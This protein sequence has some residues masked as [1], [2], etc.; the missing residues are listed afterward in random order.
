MAE[1][2]KIHSIKSNFILNILRTAVSFLTPL[3]VFPY[4]SRV[5]G[6]ENIGKVDFANSIISYFVLFTALGIPTYGVREV[7]RTRDDIIS[8]SK[9]VWELTIILCI[10]VPLGYVCYFFI[11]RII[12][13]FSKELLLFFTVAPSLFFSNFSYEWFYFGIEDQTYITVRHIFVKLLQI[14]GVYLFIREKEDYLLYALIIVGIGGISSIFNI[15]HLQTFVQR[16]PLKDLNIKH[17]IKPVLIIFTSIIATS[18]Y[19]QLDVTMVGFFSGDKAV[20]LY[21][22]ANRFVRTMIMLVTSLSSVIIP[23][24]ENCLKNNDE[25]ACKRYLDLSLHYI[26]MFSL[27]MMFGIIALGDD[28]IYILAGKQY[29]ESV[30]T[31]QLLSP[32]IVIVGLAYFVGLQILY[33]YRQ[34][35]KYTLAVSIAAFVNA[36]VNFLLIPHLAQNGAVIGTLVAELL[37]LLLQIIFASKHIKKTD[38]IS[39]NTLKYI[40]AA[41][42]MFVT[43]IF[44]P[45][46]ENVI[47]HFIISVFI[48]FII[49]GG[50]LLVLREKLIKEVWRKIFR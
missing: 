38:L 50:T 26:L 33:P 22:T 8:R 46:F 43:L 21:T 18:I 34:E 49:Y 19:M 15:F 5:L 20:G 12:P 10:T 45:S 35:W 2:L 23:R 27:P 29:V 7:A 6:P 17:H 28:I 31:I 48:A 24:I 9:T 13:E 39:V 30:F 40:I 1:Q 42:L 25:I 37:G 11:V 32:I 14:I 47:V 41:I 4:V 3:I 36:I 16:I 44:L